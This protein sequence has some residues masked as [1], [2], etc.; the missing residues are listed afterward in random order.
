MIFRK[1]FIICLV[2]TA[3]SVNFYAQ[4]VSS[5]NFPT[6]LKTEK[7]SEFRNFGECFVSMEIDNLFI[8]LQN[9]STLKGVII[10]Y[11]GTD[12]LPSAYDVLP[13]RIYEDHIRLRRYDRSKVEIINGGFRTEQLTEIWLVPPGGK[14]PS[15]SD[16]VPKPTLPDK[17]TFLYGR[18]YVDNG[19]YGLSIGDEGYLD[20]Y[21]LPAVKAEREAEKAAFEKELARE[22]NLIEDETVKEEPAE[23]DQLTQEEIENDKFSWANAKF[24]EILKNRK[25]S[26]GIIVFYADDQTYDINGLQTFIEQGRSRI[27]KEAGILPG[28]IQIVF[29]GYRSQVETELWIMPRN[30]EFP[31]M[32]PQER[33]IEEYE[34]EVDA[35]NL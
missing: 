4:D 3:V 23:S 24:G 19:F 9:D 2:L 21:L 10:A 32:T 33:E 20:K 25:D 16:T 29:G 11:Q 7:I 1:L 22:N 34:E 6:Y 31:K 28:R 35:E 8:R 30:G 5:S 18:D 12:I 14:M 26:T 13:T 15:P 17:K 27:A